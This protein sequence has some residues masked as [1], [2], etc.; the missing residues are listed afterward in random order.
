[1][2]TSYAI[3]GLGHRSHMFLH[4]LIGEYAA[5]GRLVGLCDSNPGRLAHAAAVARNAGAS[6]RTY[7]AADFDRMLRETSPECV[8][9]T[10]PD[11]A[12]CKYIVRALALGA[13]V[14]T[15]KPLTIDA[16]SCRQIVAA[17]Q[18][19][20]RS[21]TVAFN[22]RYSPARV[23]LKQVLMSGII[24]RVTAV[25]FEWQL[26]TYHGADYFRRWHRNKTNSGGLFVHKATHHFDLLNWWL[27]SVPKRVAARGQRV[28]YRPET[29]EAFGLT[30][31]GERCSDCAAF[32]R[33]RFK[34]NV[35]ASTHLQAL[36]ADNEGHD[37]YFRDRCVFSSAID[38]EDTMHA[39]IEY[40]NGGIVNYLLTAYNPGEGYRAIFHGTRGIATLEQVERL[41]LREDGS[42]VDPPFPER[43]RL[44]VQPLF[45]QPYQLALPAVE[46]LHSGG[47]RVMLEHLFRGGPNEGYAQAADERAGA[48]SA[49]VG[50]AAN[51][52]LASGAPVALA[53]IGADIP[54]PETPA[55]PFG[56]PAAW[57]VFDESRYRFLTGAR[58]I[59]GSCSRRAMVT[60]RAELS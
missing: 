45:S 35:A 7:G 47:D 24:G 60:K 46:G 2:S 36:Y 1:M 56:S 16:A 32:E 41:F 17:R 6:L 44:L 49:L 55:E 34:L 11:Y 40:E 14:I 39:T 42:L 37:G 27:G 23:L 43:T 9:V 57:Q 12:H 26:D 5:D 30:G 52:S 28:F 51:A 3:V 31:H 25:N 48:W 59:S 8:I 19:S 58:I 33:C 29:A 13:N 18:A 54:R 15:E 38:I 20:G 10:V 21:V 22:Y 53:D 50:I 4:A